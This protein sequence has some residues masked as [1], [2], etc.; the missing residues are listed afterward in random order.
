MGLARSLWMQTALAFSF[1]LF[2]SLMGAGQQAATVPARVTQPVNMENLVTLRGNTHPLARPEYDQGAAPDGLPT[3]RML[4]VLQRSAEQEAALRNLLD[5]QQIKSSPNFHMWLTPEQFGQQFG[6]ADADIQAVTD[7]FASQGFQVNHVATGRTVIEFSG[8]AGQVRQAFHTEIHKYVVK[9]EEYWA[10]ASDPQIPAALAPVVAGFASL[11]NFPRKPSH[12]VLGTFSR[13]KATGKVQPL[14][15][16]PYDICPSG[17]CYA[18]GPTDFATIYNV[19]PLWQGSPAID[20]TGQT[21]AISQQSDIDPQDVADFRTM[22]GLPTSGNYLQVIYNGPDPG[23]LLYSG[24]ETE[25][26]LDVEWAGAVAKGATIDLVVSEGTEVTYGIDLSAL[27][28]IDN[29]LAPIMSESY[30]GCEA[31]LGNSSIAFYNTLWEQ[32]AAQG[33]TILISSGDSGS[34]GCDSDGTAAQYGLAISGIASTPFNVVVGGTDFN[35]V[36]NWPQYWNPPSNTSP[37]P[38]S[39]INSAKSYIPETTWN[40]SCANTGN[41][42]GCASGVASDG[43]DLA[44]GGGG[45]SNCA[46]STW[47]STS[48][49]TEITCNAGIT[50]PA[51]QTGPGVPSDGVRDVPDV[52]LFAS[53]GYNGSFYIICETDYTSQTGGSA[54]CD[55]NAPYQDFLGLGGTSASTPAFAGIMAMVNQ[56]Y[57]RQGNANYVLY[58]MAVPTGARCPST[59]LMAPTANASSCIF[60]DVQVGNNSVACDAG[61]YN[62]SNQTGSG[63]GILVNPSNSTQAAWLTTAGYDYATGLGTVNAYNLV[64]KWTSNFQGTGTTLCLGSPCATTPIT[65]THGTQVNFTVNVTPAAAGDVSLVAP[66]GSS[67]SNSTGIGPFTL[68]SGTFS[69]STNMLPGGTYGVTAHYAGN[70][71]DGSSSSN[72]VTVTVNPETSLTDVQLVSEDCNGNF[73]YGLTTVTYGEVLNCSGALYLGY[74]LRVDVTNST[75]SVCYSS[76]TGIPTYPCPT[77]QVTVTDNGQPPPDLGEPSGTTPGTYTLNSQGHAEDQFIQLPGGTNSV[78]A[79]YAGNASYTGSKSATDT[80]TV[81]QAATTTTIS[82][83]TTVTS[84]APVILT[85]VVSTSSVGFAPSGGVQFYNRGNLIGGIPIYTPANA[86]AT[87]YA[88]LTATLTTSFTANASITAQYSGDEN[89]QGSTSAAVPITITSGAPSLSLSTSTLTFG[90]QNVGTTSASQPVTLSNT[91]NAALTI[92]NIGANAN[93]G[94]TNNC[95]TSL[96]ASGSCTINVSFA[97]TA[98]GPLIGTLTITDNSNGVAGSTQSVVLSGTGQDFSFAAASGS[99]TSVTVARGSAASYTLSVGGEGGFNQSVSFTCTGAPSEATCAVSPN[100]VTAGSSATNVTVS[101]TTTAPSLSAPRSRPLPP[102]PPLSPGLRGLLM[103]ALVLALMAWAIGRRKQPGASRW[104][105]TLVLLAS[106]L[107]LTLALAGCGGGGSAV[108]PPSNPGTPAGTY[109][110]TVTGTSGSGS[111]A[112]SHSVTLTMTVS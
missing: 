58:P 72:S 92:T 84:G 73:Y 24:D 102:A 51:W 100:P 18:V 14:F 78:V 48:S 90:N 87:A 2:F 106:G 71:T 91:G 27:Y 86:S 69:G 47:V 65:I 111:S 55:L 3:E 43:S 12:H 1:V 63:Y 108:T 64:Q 5:E 82:A 61:T 99:P 98:A 44:A 39:A 85:A 62:C 34:A 110:L 50:K 38:S 56:K 105:F 57:G 52:S 53:N 30:N 103:L 66:V 6:P 4:L 94:Q 49:G 26:D 11:N 15:T 7:W 54:S 23:L 31:F 76:S 83:A 33:I 77:G 21:I 25:A 17:T 80:I 75:G 46:N 42:A 74:W 101:V 28:I 97:P 112:L 89:Y 36:N 70:G 104:Q 16:Y 59:S 32:G 109:T 88:S 19:L 68:S 13:S 40:D 107:L 93:F 60:Y 67:P 9:G 81:T 45:P 37:P 20:G 96:A 41:V 95:G 22:F 10:N 35:D 79:T 8:T 29:N